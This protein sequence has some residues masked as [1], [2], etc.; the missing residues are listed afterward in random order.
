MEQLFDYGSDVRKVMY[1]T[2]A[3]ESV[4]ASFRKV[5]KKGSFPNEDAVYK[6]LYLRI[7]ELDK[8]WEKGNYRNWSM[9]LNQ[10]MINEKY[11][12]KIDKYLS[13]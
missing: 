8:K 7:K 13:R 12:P 5:V 3:I 2:N 9:V 1:T 6:V 11:G 4:N 10:L